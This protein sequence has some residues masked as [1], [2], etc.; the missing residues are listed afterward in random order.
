LTC[1]YSYSAVKCGEESND[2]MA[3]AVEIGQGTGETKTLGMFFGPTNVNLWRI[4]RANDGGES[5]Y[6]A[7]I[8]AET[9]PEIIGASMRIVDFHTELARAYARLRG[10][11]SDAVRQMLVAERVAPQHLYT[12][13]I[14]RE[15]ARHL[16]GVYPSR[17]GVSALKGLCGRIGID[18]G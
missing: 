1:A 16:I 17:S 9:N 7:E 12:S 14:A 6:A 15:T 10:R 3:T 13:P 2:H 11:E 4:A 5:G 8:A 18:V